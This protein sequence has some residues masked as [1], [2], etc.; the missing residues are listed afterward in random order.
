MTQKENKKEFSYEI[1]T[2]I[3]VIKQMQ[4][5]WTRELNV[6][7]WN[8]GPAKL[9]IREWS[10][11]HQH[12]SKGMTLYRNE[13]E[14]LVK[15]LSEYLLETAEAG[16]VEALPDAEETEQTEGAEQAE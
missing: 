4:S 16:G 9:D 15:L 14:Q 7:S 10:V 12:M 2:H 1:Q 8:G 3:G 13:A 6:I 5:G 11:D